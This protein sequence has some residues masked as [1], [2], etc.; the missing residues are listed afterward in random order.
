MFKISL[1]CISEHEAS[2]DYVKPCLIFFLLSEKYL[3]N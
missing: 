3:E 1:C 2:L